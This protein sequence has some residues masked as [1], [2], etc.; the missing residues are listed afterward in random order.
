MLPAQKYLLFDADDTLWENNIYFERAIREFLELLRPVAPEPQAVK[1]LLCAV[2][3][4]CIPT[5]GYGTQNFIRA[6]KETF[7]RL[8]GGN[9]GAAYHRGIE[10]IGNRLLNHPIELLP[11]VVSTLESLRA[12]HRLMLF[13]K[14]DALEQRGKLERSGLQG[15]FEQIEV[16]QEKNVAAYQELIRRHRLPPESSCMIGNSPRSDVVP[17]LAAGLW[18]VF[19]PH[20]HTWEL[21]DHP[22]ETHPRLLHAPSIQALPSLLS[23][24]GALSE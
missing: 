20:A 22:L 13:T 18:A 8:S 7:R 23:S 24:M 15:F 9:D 14:G 11:G 5:G 3:R 10:Q 4:E 17:A 2:E 1:A 12:D 16:A 21:E 19:V 6:L